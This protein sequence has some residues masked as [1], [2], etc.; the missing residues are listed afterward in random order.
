MI[1]HIK[2]LA[3]HLVPK[4]HLVVISVLWRGWILAAPCGTSHSAL[5]PAGAPFILVGYLFD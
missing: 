5:H 3:K 2:F 4:K 1:N